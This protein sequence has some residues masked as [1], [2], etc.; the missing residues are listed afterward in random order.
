MGPLESDRGELET[1]VTELRVLQN[2][3]I[4]VLTVMNPDF[5]NPREIIAERQ[6]E[7]LTSVNF[8]RAEV[9]KYIHKLNVIKSPD[10]D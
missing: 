10:P 7:D 6:V 4:F 1:D 5:S 8:P 2:H 9:I 3:H